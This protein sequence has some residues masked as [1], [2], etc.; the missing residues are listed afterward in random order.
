VVD[1]PRRRGEGVQLG[2]VERATRLAGRG[3]A[4]GNRSGVV[5]WGGRSGWAEGT[6]GDVGPWGELYGLWL[7]PYVYTSRRAD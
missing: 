5:S 7:S 4:S 6:V 1:R 2:M 3:A